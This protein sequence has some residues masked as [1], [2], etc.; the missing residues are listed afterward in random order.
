[1]RDYIKNYLS[2]LQVE[3][4]LAR[5]SLVNYLND[6]KRLEKHAALIGKPLPNLEKVELVQWLRHQSQ[7]G[8]SS[9]TMARRISSVRGFYKYLLLDGV[10]KQSPAEELVQPRRAKQ[11]PKYLSED[12]VVK[13]IETV[14]TRTEEGM[15]DRAMLELLYATGLR[16]SELVNLNTAEI[17]LVRALLKC[18][19]KGNK[20]RL[21]P[22]GRD[23]VHALHK[24]LDIRFLICGGKTSAYLFVKGGGKGLTRQ[25]VWKILKRYANETGIKNANPHSWRHSFATHLTQRGADSR[26]VQ[27]LLGHSDLSTTQVYTHLSKSNL[28]ET[29]DAFH[30]RIEDKRS[31]R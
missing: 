27:A 31:V 16:V 14:N 17:D 1:L 30:P 2:F 12:E 20:Q 11:L 15:R 4:G 26:T 6:L 13:L 3:K 25:D 8:L 9:E 23:A 5:N 19:G 18:S 29:L 24:Y 7:Q 22:I 10:I 28:R 21:I